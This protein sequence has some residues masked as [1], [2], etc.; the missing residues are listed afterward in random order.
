VEPTDANL[1]EGLQEIIA[2]AFGC[3]PVVVGDAGDETL[4]RL[5]VLGE[6]GELYEWIASLS[7]D[8]RWT[9]SPVRLS[10]SSG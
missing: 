2:Y 4:Y 9:L 6:D 10:Y 8:H 3:S 5:I 7:L 1:P